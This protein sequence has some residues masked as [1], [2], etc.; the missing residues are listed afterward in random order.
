MSASSGGKHHI[1]HSVSYHAISDKQQIRIKIDA[2]HLTVYFVH[3]TKDI[4]SFRTFYSGV[5]SLKNVG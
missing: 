2:R 3:S 5:V 1:L 4:Y